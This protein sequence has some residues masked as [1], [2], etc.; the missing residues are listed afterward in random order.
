MSLKDD[1]RSVFVSCGCRFV[2]NDVV[3]FILNIFETM[4]FCEIYKIITD[5]SGVSGTMRDLSDFLKIIK[6]FFWFAIF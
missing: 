3:Q 1:G 5:L 2:D 6:D 4:F